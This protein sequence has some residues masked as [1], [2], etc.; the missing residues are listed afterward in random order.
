MLKRNCQMNQT[1]KDIL[2]RW[3]NMQSN[4]G[5]SSMVGQLTSKNT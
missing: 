4:K 2:G 5:E 3:I 1:G